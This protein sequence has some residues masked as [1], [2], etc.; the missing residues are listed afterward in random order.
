MIKYVQK[1]FYISIICLLSLTSS[2]SDDPA[3][4]KESPT[5]VVIDGNP[6]SFNF[7]WT[8]ELPDGSLI[9]SEGDSTFTT[10]NP[11]NYTLTWIESSQW[12]S[13]PS[14]ESQILVSGETITF[15][16]SYH[17]NLPL[18]TTPDILISNNF[19]AGHNFMLAQKLEAMLHLDF[20]AMLSQETFD[21]WQNSDTPPTSLFFNFNESVVIYEN[22]FG[23]AEGYDSSGYTSP[24]VESISI[25]IFQKTT[26][27]IPADESD[28]FFHALGASK[29]N[30]EILMYLNHGQNHRSEVNQNISFYVLQNTDNIWKLLGFSSSSLALTQADKSTEVIAYDYILTMYR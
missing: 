10:M 24:A 23:G 14:D 18:A 25:E 3:S 12:Y 8:L 26:D 6:D 5:S 27:W 28:G 19:Y 22:L 1:F 16:G 15:N 30:Y 13:T 20:R 2:C 17:N 21:A 4:P 9:S 29:A 11:G 7:H